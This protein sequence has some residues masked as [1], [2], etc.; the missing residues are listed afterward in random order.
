M[1]TLDAERSTRSR[2]APHARP[3]RRAGGIDPALAL[4]SLRGFLGITFAYA[5][6]QK[7]ADP[8]F[9]HAGA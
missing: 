8:G 3:P 1:E 2:R 5:G 7:L 9:F 6:L 4:V